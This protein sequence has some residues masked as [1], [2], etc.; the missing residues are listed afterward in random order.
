MKVT[1]KAT[2]LILTPEIKKA[3]EEK[4]ATLDK[5]ISGADA[6]IEAFV[7]VALETRHHQK[8]EIYCAEADIR[9]PGRIIRSEAKEKNIFKAINTVKDELQRLLKKYKGIGRNR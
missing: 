2:N 1:I 7:E 5:F 8:G 9:I 6:S 4:I 3:I